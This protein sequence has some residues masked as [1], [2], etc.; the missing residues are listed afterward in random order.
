MDTQ[1]NL[2]AAENVAFYL[3]RS[4]RP[5]AFLMEGSNVYFAKNEEMNAYAPQSP[6][7]NLIQGIYSNYGNTARQI[8]RNRIYSTIERPSVM[9]LGMTKVAA[10]RLTAGIRPIDHQLRLDL[11][12][13]N[14]TRRGQKV[15]QQDSLSN[16][17]HQHGIPNS[18]SR[19]KSHE[20][21]MTLVL[22]I[23]SLIPRNPIRYQ[24]DRPIACVLVA[25]DPTSHEEK[26][27]SW[28][29]SKNASDKTL[30]A[31]ICMIQDF[32][33]CTGKPL[34]RHSRIYTSLKPCRMCAS[35]IWH[36][37]EDRRTLQVYY[38]ENDP[39]RFGK[40]TILSPY[41]PDRLRSNCTSEELTLK[42]EQQLRVNRHECCSLL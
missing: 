25:P 12:F 11:T 5:V 30:H 13:I 20:D 36:C 8:I 29:I 24:S 9:C 17:L 6:V 37:T 16:Y 2:N 42:I 39:G 35:M 32:F 41:T 18:L 19:L 1:I 3:S 40:S 38:A 10:K 21:F 26:V 23:A 4:G 14:V 34:P 28:G 33:Q 22:Q 7:V 27:L 15:V 31:E